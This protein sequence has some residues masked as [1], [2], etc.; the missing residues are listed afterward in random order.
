MNSP[1]T[2]TVARHVAIIMDGNGR[3]AKRRSLGR[4]LGH[5]EGIVS[6]REV[7]KEAVRQGVRYLTVYAFSTE[8][9][10][11]PPKEVGALMGLMARQ[12]VKEAPDLVSQGVRL[13]AIGGIDQLP[14]NARASIARVEELTRG[15]QVLDFV[16]ALS[17]GGRSEICDAVKKLLAK[18]VAPEDI[19]EQAI[20][21]NLYAPDIP[22]PDLVIR[23]SG[24]MRLSNFL[25]WQSAYSEIYFTETLWPD[26]RAAEFRLALEQF[27]RRTRRFGLTDEQLTGDA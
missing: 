6:L 27:A 7:I 11:R 8:N 12:L 4:V 21:A 1:D 13:R 14:Q 17:Y 18:G 3:W 10:G 20:S 19:D 15:G 23:T 22:D 26:F 24:E 16:L 2:A 25:L 9:W 5:R